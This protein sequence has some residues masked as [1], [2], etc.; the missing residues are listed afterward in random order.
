MKSKGH[1]CL[2]VRSPKE[3]AQ[4]H[5]PGA[6]NLPIFN[7]E[8]RARIGIA[9]KQQSRAI[10]IEIGLEIVGPKMVEFVRAVKPLVKANQVFVHCWRGGMRSGSMAWLFSL[11]GYTVFTLEGGYK[12]YRHHVLSALSQPSRYVVIGGF[13]GSGKTALLQHLA[14]L[15]EQVIDLEQLAHHKGSAFGGLLETASPTSE[16]FENNLHHKLTAMD[17]SKP[18]WLEDE[19]RHIGA[20]YLPLG[21]W[22]Q[23]RQSYLIILNIPAQVRLAN[24]LIEYESV[25]NKA[26]ITSFRKIERRLGNEATKTAILHLESGAKEAAAKIALRYYD[27]SYTHSLSL[28]ENKSHTIFAF[29]KIDVP[30]IAQTLL[31]HVYPR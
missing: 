19:S 23:I 13:T 30:Y 28:K 31:N 20:C 1:L 8:E 29:T 21:F 10:A 5:L 3:F 11:L 25:T 16:Q 7:N 27:K 24:L 17:S 15:G 14:S 2:D 26:L 4:G 18:I 6:I 12:A 22:Q 9:Y